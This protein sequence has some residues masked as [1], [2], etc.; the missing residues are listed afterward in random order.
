MQACGLLA[1]ELPLNNL[2]AE[3]IVQIGLDVTGNLG[4]I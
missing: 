1:S 2:V 3:L 4:H